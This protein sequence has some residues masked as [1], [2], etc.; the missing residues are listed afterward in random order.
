MNEQLSHIYEFDSFRLVPAERQLLRDGQPVALP[1]K[2]F[3]TLVVLVRNSGRVLKKD[4]LIKQVWPDSFVEESNLNHYISVLRKTLSDGANGDGYVETVRGYGFRFNADVRAVSQDSS[5]HLVHRHTRTQVVFKEEES[6]SLRTVSSRQTETVGRRQTAV[7]RK[8]AMIFATSCLI[9]GAV[10]AAYFGYVR[11]AHLRAA[12]AASGEALPVRRKTAENPAAREAYLK[13]RYYW[14][15]RTADDIWRAAHEFKRALEIDS[16]YAP[17]Y[18]GMADCLLMGGAA[19]PAITES[20]KTLALKALAIDGNLAEAHATLAYY[21]SAIEWDWSGAEREFQR[22]ISLDPG[23]VT[24][25]HWHAYNLASLGRMD[26]ALS[27]ISR[28]RDLD[29]VSV[30]ISTDVGEMLYFAGRYDEA[31]TQYLKALALDP[32][33]RLAHVR[34]SEAYT[35]TGKHEEAAAELKEVI[36][37]DPSRESEMDSWLA[38]AAALNGRREEALKILNHLKMDLEFHSH[39]K[40]IASIYSGLGDKDSAFAWLEKALNAHE[41]G[42]ALVKVDP[43]LKS[44]HSDPRFEELL[45]RVNLD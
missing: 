44:L 17:A 34:L 36:R 25:H 40:E 13:G 27:E 41:P 11:P 6:Q 5:S 9:I 21:Q 4:D 10:A 23:Y 33:F 8:P 43:M 15:K 26:E 32:G 35:Q 28:A 24:A 30:N 39:A 42:A 22:A 38:F 14:R 2:A 29:P 45:R 20:P 18:V 16:N 3:D 37:L 1:P 7:G 31:I 19:N 12:K